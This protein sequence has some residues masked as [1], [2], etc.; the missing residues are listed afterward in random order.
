MRVMTVLAAAL[1]LPLLSMSA[2]AQENS[3]GI[4]VSQAWS[5]ATP[6][7]MRTGAAYLQITASDTE[8][9]RLVDARSESAERV[10]IHNHIHENGVMRM[11]RVESIELP[12]GQ[13]VILAPGG[14]HLMLM[15]LKQPLRVGDKLDLTLVFEKAG[16]VEVAATVEPIGAKGPGMAAGDGHGSGHGKGEH[17]H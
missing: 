10:E 7:G 6:G 13:T 1:L 2:V 17:K 15:G 12:A 9:D 4:T 16:A 8:G 14:F 3:S 11:R 5:R